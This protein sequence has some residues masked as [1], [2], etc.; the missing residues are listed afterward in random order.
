[1]EGS[2]CLN[3]KVILQL[4]INLLQSAHFL[5]QRSKNL[6]KLGILL[7]DIKK[8]VKRKFI[9]KVKRSKLSK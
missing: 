5:I 6:G 4:Q 1:M 3:I 8:K 7:K 9:L 2:L